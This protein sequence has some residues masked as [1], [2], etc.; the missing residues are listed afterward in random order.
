[1]AL[2]ARTEIQTFLFAVKGKPE[3]PMASFIAASDKASRYLL[4]GM[5]KHTSDIVKE[6]E[7][8]V[9]GDIE[10][11]VLNHNGRLAELKSKIRREI[12]EGLGEGIENFQ[13]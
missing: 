9:L 5:K 1:M 2:N 11:L 6:F 7:S 12:R 8:Y 4:H 10:G 3:H 13:E